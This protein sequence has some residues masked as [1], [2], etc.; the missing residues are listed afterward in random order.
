MADKYYTPAEYEAA[1]HEPWR[2]RDAVY[3]VDF[4]DKNDVDAGYRFWRVGT[5]E[6][7]KYM[8]DVNNGDVLCATTHCP[9]DN[10]FHEGRANVAE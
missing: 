8:D 4:A 1:F 5:L 9:A 2:D 6:E 7:L 3:Y 10:Y